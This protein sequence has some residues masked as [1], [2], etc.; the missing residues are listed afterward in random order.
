M[1]GQIRGRIF[2]RPRFSIDFSSAKYGFCFRFLKGLK[3]VT[4]HLRAEAVSRDISLSQITLRYTR[5]ISLIKMPHRVRKYCLGLMKDKY[6]AKV[7]KNIVIICCPFIIL[8]RQKTCTL[9]LQCSERAPIND[10][11]CN[12]MLCILQQS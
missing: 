3:A 12:N 9:T 7:C 2:R 8:C 5:G 1:P 11:I 6:S 4:F 10:W